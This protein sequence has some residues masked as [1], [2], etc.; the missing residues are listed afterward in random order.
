MCKHLLR[1]KNAW[2]Q[3]LRKNT[4]DFAFQ[5]LTIPS[6]FMIVIIIFK[7]VLFKMS[8]MYLFFL[9]HQKRKVNRV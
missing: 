8:K 7:W 6:M 5:L 4:K 3:L 2:V 1:E 9:F